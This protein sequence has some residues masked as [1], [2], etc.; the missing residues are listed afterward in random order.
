MK[1]LVRRNILYFLS[2]ALLLAVA[3]SFKA[4]S[5]RTAKSAGGYDVVILGG[6][7]MDPETNLDAVRNVGIRNGEIA[8]ITTKALRG[9]ARRGA[10]RYNCPSGCAAY[11]IFHD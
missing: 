1:R 11:G 5:G 7:V 9:A 8:A 6:R 3:C 2:A 10:Q 4:A